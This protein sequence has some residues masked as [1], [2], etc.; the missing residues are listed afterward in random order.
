MEFLLQPLTLLT[1]FP[2]VGVLVI[3]LMN[4]EQK[5]AIRWTALVTSL[6][7]LVISLW[8]LQGFYA[9]EAGDAGALHLE[10]KYAWITVAGWNIYYYLAVDGLSILL[11]LLTAFLTPISLLSTWTAV[12]DRVKEFMIFFLLLE[13]GMMGVFLAQDLFL[14]YIFWEFTLVPMYF[15]IGLW[16]GPRR[17][18]A[19]VKFFLYTMAGSILMLVAILYLGNQTKTFNIPEMLTRLPD[20]YAR[21]ATNGISDSTQ[22]LLFIAFAAAFAIKV[23]MWPLHSWLPD[24]H[25]EAPTAGS[26]ILAGVLLKMGT[27]GFLRFNIQLFPNAT[28][29]AAPWIALL[30]TIGIIYGAAVSYAQQDVKKLVAYSSVSHLGFVMLGL[31]AL[32]PEGVAGAILQM[33]NHGLSTGA[34]F[35]LIG[36]IYEQTHTRDIKVYGGLWKITPVFGTIMLIAS[37]SSMGLPGLNGFVG[38]FTILLGAFGSKAIGSPWYAGVSA[39]GVI[40]AAVYILYMFQKVFLG[41]AG[42][43]THHH[44]L[45]DLNARELI[46]VVPLVIFMFWIGLYPAPFFNI[47]APAVK[48]LLEPI[49]KI[50]ATL[51]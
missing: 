5:T 45:K 17:L 32:N 24:A 28:V 31:F 47:L 35:L 12:E 16:G 29:A 3:L 22:M 15:L 8:V 27:Y 51:P 18:Y 19:A 46:T 4:E 43:I 34:L 36:M 6:I 42:E 21:G 23:P 38:E 50:L 11:V 41:P 7:T 14:F 2:L 13:V 40:M 30:A 1:F 9:A 48:H 10:A 39:A 44:E 25:V 33:I 49:T 20:L 37:L 26:V